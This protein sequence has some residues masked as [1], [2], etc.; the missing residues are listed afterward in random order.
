M[1]AAPLISLVVATRNAAAHLPRCL[2]SLRR[3]TFREFEVIVMDGASTDATPAILAAA[4]DVV[5]AWRSEPDRGI[6]SAWNK[7]LDAARGEWIG[8]LGADDWLW[9]EHALEQ[10]VPQLR[11]APPG[12]RVVYSRLRQVDARGRVAEE[13]GEP[14]ERARARFRSYACLP[15]PGLMHR[16]SLFEAHGR[17]DESFQLAGDYE[18]LLRELKTGE[19]I[20]VPTLTVGMD[21][22]GKTTSPEHFLQL[23]REVA[24]ALAM[25]GLAP[26]RLRWAWWTLS[27]WLYRGLHALVG[28]R[29]ARRL[30]DLYRVLTLRDARYSGTREDPH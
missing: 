26:P 28:D 14:W 21:L 24:R 17:F 12:C 11:S 23:Q 7:G 30:A 22:G 18:L 8:F 29:A 5:S 3:Q 2:D 4:G 25:H 13:L 6:Y 16:R 1:A 10:L 9:D 19:A 20:Y 15:Q 27:A